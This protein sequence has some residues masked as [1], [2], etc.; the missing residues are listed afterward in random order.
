MSVTSTPLVF[1]DEALELLAE[2]ANVAQ[3]VSFDHDLRIRYCR[4]RGISP[5]HRFKTPEAAVEALLASAP[6]Q[7]VNIRSF[8]PEDPQGGEFVPLLSSPQE[9]V[10]HLRRLS[11]D[12]FMIVNESVD[13]NDGGV[14]GVS[15]GGLCEFAPGK[16]PRCVEEEEE[17]A[18]LPVDLALSVFQRVYG[19]RPAL[20][21][22]PSRR[23]E[24]SIHPFPRGLKHTKTI[25]WE[26]QELETPRLSNQIRWPNA[27]SRMLGDKVYGLVLADALGFSVPRTN[28]IARRIPPFTFGQPS[29][30]LQKWVRTAPQVK[31]PGHFSTIRGWTDPFRLMSL[32]DPDGTKLSS[33]LVQDE[34]EAAY[35]GALVTGADSVP[36]IEGVKGFGDRFMLGE[37][38]PERIPK[39]L[40]PQLAPIHARLNQSLGPVRVEWAHD[41]QLT[42][43][44]Q[45]QQDA[46]LSHG[47]TIYPGEPSSFFDFNVSEFDV[48]ER[49]ENLRLLVAKAQRRSAGIRMIGDIGQTS[50]LAEVLRDSKIPS[51]KVP[52][53]AVRSAGKRSDRASSWLLA[54]LWSYFIRRRNK[55]VEKASLNPQ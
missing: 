12:F 53:G 7:K 27:F 42:W 55:F 11:R 25:I 46:A 19:F 10:R 38:G 23:V 32:E 29:G 33:I 37:R 40:T 5:K 52:R 16:T 36:I 30:S 49:L 1:K 20:E 3:F 22:P 28:V 21:Y 4:I 15:Q 34:V 45:L 54:T 13:V 43:I 47:D 44:L 31:T 17:V 14:S 2:N 39:K 50:H 26:L 9:V 35:S 51:L 6:E 24:F 41:G 18:A 48:K 8:K